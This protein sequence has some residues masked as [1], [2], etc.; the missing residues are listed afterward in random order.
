MA[1]PDEHSAAIGRRAD[2]EETP[3]FVLAHRYVRPRV[4]EIR[5]ARPSS[6]GP[7]P[8]SSGGERNSRAVPPRRPRSVA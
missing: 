1:S 8:G 4:R 3:Q 2:D 7:A 6:F 5:P